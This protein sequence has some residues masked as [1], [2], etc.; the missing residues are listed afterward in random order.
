M[1]RSLAIPILVTLGIM[2]HSLTAVGQSMSSAINEIFMLW[3]K[4]L[5]S[6]AAS[7]SSSWKPRA[8]ATRYQ[9]LP[10]SDGFTPHWQAAP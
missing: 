2:G 8:V 7:R 10:H 1:R 5:V 4:L 6:D 9:S 3:M